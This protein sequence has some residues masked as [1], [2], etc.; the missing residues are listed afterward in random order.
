MYDA[1][2]HQRALAEREAATAQR[3]RALNELREAMSGLEANA[4]PRSDLHDRQCDLGTFPLLGHGNGLFW[5][6][7]T[8]WLDVEENEERWTFWEGQTMGVETFLTHPEGRERRPGTEHHRARAGQRATH[9]GP[10]GVVVTG[11][12]RRQSAALLRGDPPVAE[13]ETE[14]H[15]ALEPLSRLSTGQGNTRMR[16]TG[17]SPETSSIQVTPV[18]SDANT[19]PSEVPNATMD[20][21]GSASRQ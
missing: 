1:L 4:D 2:G 12:R 7:P 15:Q 8:I 13:H 9:P 19:W 18:S 17:G 14:V 3:L 20:P 6:R 5:E 10:S 11:T 16:C 21:S